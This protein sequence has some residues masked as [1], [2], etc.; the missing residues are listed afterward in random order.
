[1]HWL[2][3]SAQIV[4]KGEILANVN[5]R[6]PFSYDSAKNIWLLEFGINHWTVTIDNIGGTQPPV[7]PNI[8]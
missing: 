3:P 8:M 1:M 5:D 6:E 2:F 7:C 4:N